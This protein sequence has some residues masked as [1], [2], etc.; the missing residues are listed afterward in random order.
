MM[1]YVKMEI[2]NINTNII[3]TVKE[4]G[5]DERT[6]LLSSASSTF[7]FIKKSMQRCTGFSRGQTFFN[8][9]KA[10]R[11]CL[12]DYADKICKFMPD[13]D[14][15]T[16][17]CKLQDG[18]EVKI[19]YIVNTCDYCAEIVEQL[20]NSIKTQIDPL[21]KENIDFSEVQDCFH[22][23]AAKAVANLVSGLEEY[24][25]PAM[26]SMVSFLPFVS[27]PSFRCSFLPPSLPSSSFP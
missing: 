24:L 26:K 3:E 17:R 20:E 27:L 1:S 12:L 18:D 6:G 5:C 22:E 8:L 9:Q 15:K 21:Y 11:A 16:G 14:T 13:P 23:T 7:T 19:C 2:L 25:Q 4:W 10:Y